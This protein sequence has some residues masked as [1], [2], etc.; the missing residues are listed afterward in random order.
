MKQN[1]ANELLKKLQKDKYIDSKT[2]KKVLKFSDKVLEKLNKLNDAYLSDVCQVLIL[3]NNEKERLEIIK[4]FDV[5]NSTK[6]NDF[7]LAI[8]KNKILKNHKLAI[9]HA[10][11]FAQ[12]NNENNENILY[13]F[14]T[15]E[16]FTKNN[17][18]TKFINKISKLY[19]DEYI[20]YEYILN[21]IKEKY[22]DTYIDTY[23]KLLNDPDKL[24][25][26][27]A[28]N[29]IMKNTFSNP[30]DNIFMA[31]MIPFLNSILYREDIIKIIVN[32]KN[33]FVNVLRENEQFFRKE[34]LSKKEFVY[35][36]FK[37]ASKN[38]FT[39][40]E[41]N[42]GME[43]ITKYYIN[44][45]FEEEKLLEALKKKRFKEIDEIVNLGVV[46]S[47]RDVLSLANLDSKIYEKII[48]ILK[49][50]SDYINVTLNCVRDMDKNL[51]TLVYIINIILKYAKERT[52]KDIY[53]VI[54]IMN[55]SYLRYNNLNIAYSEFYLN[56]NN[57][58]KRNLYY[59]IMTKNKFIKY[60]EELINLIKPVNN[61]YLLQLLTR[62]MATMND[63]EELLEL[64]KILVEFDKN[65]NFKNE[66]S[67]TIATLIE[68]IIEEY[69]NYNLDDNAKNIR[70]YILNG[71][72]G[73][74]DEQFLKENYDVIY[75][76]LYE[77]MIVKKY[78]N[79]NE[80]KKIIQDRFNINIDTFEE[81]R[82][83]KDII[84]DNLI[85]SMENREEVNIR[86]LI[87]NKK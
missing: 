25:A 1:E 34:N 79:L 59:K 16:F 66:E 35:R 9:K 54:D 75:Y 26:G 83:R 36:F 23:I 37:I 4:L 69:E 15:D 86:K 42:K 47:S 57:E 71:L 44:G 38:E 40:D 82:A 39:K 7:L 61:D 41:V 2:L 17:L 21:I 46:N 27:Y 64:F 68:S 74:N 20:D 56:E 84:I 52:P 5:Y 33:L 50:Y 3:Y 43:L 45:Y 29:F 6:E 49:N 18:V 78:E 73:I 11:I 8:L 53:N 63:E 70:N 28:Y 62:Y 51:E 58:L 10:Q 60:K 12:Y 13:N 76:W 14:L 55:D 67:N 19:S 31:K 87:K 24:V 30:E 65:E 85:S 77:A 32:N 48:Y 80:A 81:E 72:N 22:N